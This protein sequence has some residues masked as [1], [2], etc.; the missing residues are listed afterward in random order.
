ML[1]LE[2]RAEKANGA[3]P[4]AGG[5]GGDEIGET[6][7][8]TREALFGSHCDHFFFFKCVMRKIWGK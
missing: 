1:W 8:T 7:A 2:L 5:V 6:G 4:E 3:K